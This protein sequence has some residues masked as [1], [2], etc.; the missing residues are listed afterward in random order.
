M[1]GQVRAGVRVRLPLDVIREGRPTTVEIEALV[2]CVETDGPTA[3]RAW[4]AVPPEVLSVEW[5]PLP[6]FHRG[7]TPTALLGRVVPVPLTAIYEE[8]EG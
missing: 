3:G 6:K 8:P 4:C 1:S 7:E 2:L 5:D